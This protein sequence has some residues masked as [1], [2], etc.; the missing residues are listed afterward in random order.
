[1][2]LKF[3]V[4]HLL[5]LRDWQTHKDVY[6]YALEECRLA[7]E[8]GFDAVWLAEHHFSQYGICPS[9]APMAAAIAR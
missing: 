8:V 1:M 9:L 7:E 3:S 5:T 2:R 6:D 4:Q